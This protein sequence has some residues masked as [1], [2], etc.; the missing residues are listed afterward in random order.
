MDGYLSQH[1]QGKTVNAVIDGVGMLLTP[2][3]LKS[4]HSIEK[5]QSRIMLATF[6]GNPNTMII[7]CYNPTNASDETDQDTFCSKWSSFVRSVPKRNILIIAGD[8]NSQIGKNVNSKFS[9]HNSSK[10]NEKHLTDFILEN[11][12]TYLNTKFQ[13]RKGKLW[14]KNYA[15]NTK[16]ETDYILMSKKWTN[17]V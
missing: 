5:I 11:R 7:P 17:R 4:L 2:H 3:T 14:T 6:N 1:V 8:T 16:A 9:F 10:R 13:K 15:K 12:L